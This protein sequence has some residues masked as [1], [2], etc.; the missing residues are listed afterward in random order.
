MVSEE[1]LSPEQREIMRQ[2]NQSTKPIWIQ[3]HAGSG[4]SVVM[5]YA[6]SDYLIKNKNAKVA[7]VVF[8]HALKD[9]L[10]NGIKEIP[11]L[12]SKNIPVIT[13]YQMQYK[14]KN[15]PTIKYDGIF[16]DE[17]QDL[18]ITFIKDLQN[19]CTQ[20]IIAGDAAQS[21]YEKDPL[22]KLSTATVD[23]INNQIGPENKI[24]LSIFRLTKNVINILK[25]VYA[26]LLNNKEYI[27]KE[28]TEI[29]LFKADSREEETEWI[30]NE[31]KMININRSSEVCAILLFKRDDIV[32]FAN[33]VLEKEGKQCW[34]IETITKFNKEV[35]NF[36]ALNNYLHF[37]KIP[38]MYIGNNDGSL[39]RADKQ[40]KI[41]IM[42]YHS[43]KG[44]DFD[45]VCLP[46]LNTDISF[47]S[48][49][50]ALA[51]VALSRSKRD[52]VITYS[53]IIDSTFN[54][55]LNNVPVKSIDDT[56][57]EVIF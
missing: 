4:K 21:I 15:T 41:V 18:P 34:D 10:L 49:R 28:N 1:K 32:E 3:G 16:C 46:Y 20:L 29:R 55:F 48:N 40:N 42:T 31:A 24:L 25:N 6:L 12:R 11:A 56:S 51:L 19:S 2:V 57:G 22:K 39:D 13:I 36:Q 33:I 23:E 17:V 14:L 5:L 30:W 8:T 44:L 9:L 45:A 43:S 50:K 27:G 37:N 54:K 26:S 7:V 38:L 52:L 35:I 53:D 47:I